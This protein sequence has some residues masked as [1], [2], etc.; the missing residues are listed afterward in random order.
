MKTRRYLVVL[1]VLLLAAMLCVLGPAALAEEPDSE[2]VFREDLARLGAR[3]DDLSTMREEAL[4]GYLNCLFDAEETC[5]PIVQESCLKQAELYWT[6][7]TD[8][9]SVRTKAELAAATALD[10]PYYIGNQPDPFLDMPEQGAKAGN[11]YLPE[12]SFP[13][14]A[15]YLPDEFCMPCNGNDWGY[16]GCPFA[17]A[18]GPWQSDWMPGGHHWND[19][20]DAYG[21]FPHSDP[22]AHQDEPPLPQRKEEPAESPKGDETAPTG[23]GVPAETRND[24]DAYADR[25]E[26][27]KL[28]MQDL[29]GEEAWNTAALP[30]P[31]IDTDS[32]DKAA[33]VSGLTMDAPEYLPEGMERQH[34]RAMKGTVEA[35]YS[36]GE[37]ELT[38]RASLDRGGLALTGDYNSYSST[39]Q[40]K[41]GD[42]VIDCIGDGE[43]INAAAWKIGGVSYALDM[44]PGKEGLGLT[45]DELSAITAAFSAVPVK[46]EV[47]T[48]HDAAPAAP[49]EEAL[50]MPF[51]LSEDEYL[52]SEANDV[53]PEP[54]LTEAQPTGAKQTRLIVGGGEIYICFD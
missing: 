23:A 48:A 6:L 17:G 32:L 8:L 3:A 29:P 14:E 10:D 4:I 24:A 26:R 43:R 28:I 22:A 11:E 52:T 36:N 31:W 45:Y 15:D 16:A 44:A 49:S 1:T 12:E 39:W 41:V 9:L 7:Y 25:A 30:N 33:A 37:N 51:A 35:D 19:G 18:H 27:E 5:D 38:L 53:T 54:E 42:L 13:S 46:T 40:E 50:E 34:Y 20:F 2:I 47:K 21:H